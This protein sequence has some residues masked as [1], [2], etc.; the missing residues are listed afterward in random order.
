[1]NQYLADFLTTDINIHL[2]TLYSIFINTNGSDFAHYVGLIFTL[3][4]FGLFAFLIVKVFEKFEKEHPKKVILVDIFSVV[5][6]A[7]VM[8]VALK[9]NSSISASLSA[10]SGH[11]GTTFRGLI[12]YR[13]NIALICGVFYSI[14]I[15][16]PLLGKYFKVLKI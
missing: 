7:F 12:E 6:F 14:F 1:M 2:R 10:N 4:V 5:L 16:H 8:F 15:N 13:E 11:Y 9:F 3:L